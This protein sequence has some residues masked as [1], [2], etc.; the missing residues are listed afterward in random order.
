MFL[1]FD[2]QFWV[3]KE[4]KNTGI[5]FVYFVP[6]TSVYRRTYMCIKNG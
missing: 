6:V 3:K 2:S 5:D 1:Y 4:W